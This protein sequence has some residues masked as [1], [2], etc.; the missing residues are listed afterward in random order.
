MNDPSRILVMEGVGLVAN[1][2]LSEVEINVSFFNI[3]MNIRVI[4]KTGMVIVIII[5]FSLL[6]IRPP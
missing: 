5:S 4:R 1:C 6:V 2:R 3:L